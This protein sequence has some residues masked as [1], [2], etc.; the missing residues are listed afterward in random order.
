MTGMTTLIPMLP[1]NCNIIFYNNRGKGL[2]KGSLWSSFLWKNLR[3][4]G[5]NEYNDVLGALNYAK[6]LDKRKENTNFYV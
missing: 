6:S 5:A 3:H 4:Y 2:S 1:N